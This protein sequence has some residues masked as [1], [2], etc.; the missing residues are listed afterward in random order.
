MNERSGCVLITLYLM[1]LYFVKFYVSQNIIFLK[2]FS[3]LKMHTKNCNS[4]S[5]QKQLMPIVNP[6]LS[7][8]LTGVEPAE[9][10][11]MFVIRLR[12]FKTTGCVLTVQ[13]N[14][15]ILNTDAG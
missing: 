5:V 12:A 8:E 15:I 1:K 10:L 6:L 4:Q 7:P 9:T 13:F 3:H 2:I 14:C 11:P